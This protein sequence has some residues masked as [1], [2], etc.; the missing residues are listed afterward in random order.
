MNVTWH[1]VITWFYTVQTYLSLLV[2]EHL[3]AVPPFSLTPWLQPGGKARQNFN[4][5]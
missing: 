1:Q 3:D 4:R 5:F 2:H